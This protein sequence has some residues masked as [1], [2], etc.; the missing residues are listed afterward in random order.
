MNASWA[1]VHETHIGAVFLVGD[2][3]YKLKKPVDLGFLDFSSRESR[4][5]VCHREV[6]LNRRL[7]PDVYLGVADV[8]GP[9]GELL[10]H[11]VVMRRMPEDRRLSTLVRSGELLHLTIRR[12]AKQLAVF[13]ARAERGVSISAD[14]TRDKVRDRWRSSFAQVR[15]FHGEVL[16]TET[17]QEIEALTE[18]FLAGRKSLF[19][20]RIAEGRVVD[21]HGD[22]LADDVF[23]LDGG[24]RVLDCLEFDDHLR[25]VDVLDDIA[26][27]AMDLERL[28]ADEAARQLL[29]DYREFAGDPAPPA[30]VHHYLAYRAFVRV[31]VACLRHAQG[32]QEAAALARDYADLTL[33]HLRL[34]QVR[35]ILVG[36]LPGTGKSTIAAGLADRLNASLLQSD[37]LRKETAGLVPAHRPAEAYRQGLYD[38]HHTDAMYTELVRRAT[39]LLAL[40]ETVVVDASWTE[41]RHRALAAASAERTSSRL[42][43]IRCQVPEEIASHRIRDRRDTLSD[44]TV[45]IARRMAS[46]TDPWPEARTLPTTGSPSESIALAWEFLTSERPVPS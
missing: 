44:A 46:D 32:D 37:R 19:D 42:S 27:L 23:C 17:A 34:G 15:P 2:R 26:F 6:E 22:L 40:G 41:T 31:K 12:L 29:D 8:S 1:D 38:S 36:G 16:L 9:D 3:A 35:L 7:A 5:R 21:G 45:D 11:L 25:H 39:E 20:R 4:E 28:G 10:D 33:K 43:S 18:E 13:H 24:P 30:L 14:G